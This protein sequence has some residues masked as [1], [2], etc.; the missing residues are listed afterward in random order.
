M[1]KVTSLYF[2]LDVIDNYAFLGNFTTRKKAIKHMKKLTKRLNY[3]DRTDAW[4][5]P[6]KNY[7]DYSFEKTYVSKKEYKRLVEAGR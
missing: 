1:Y 4:K 7:C 3:R 5:S 2:D 6:L